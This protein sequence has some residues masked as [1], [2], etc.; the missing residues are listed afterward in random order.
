M[1][2]KFWQMGYSSF[3]DYAVVLVGQIGIYLMPLAVQNWVY[4]T[5]LRK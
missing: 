1:I 4:K 2:K 3:F 5:F